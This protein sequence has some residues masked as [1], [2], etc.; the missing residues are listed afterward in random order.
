[1][2][3]ATIAFS[4]ARTHKNTRPDKT[5]LSYKRYKKTHTHAE[6]KSK[7]LA[8]IMINGVHHHAIS[9]EVNWLCPG[10]NESIVYMAGL[11]GIFILLHV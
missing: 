1:M 2:R 4:M 10:L 9:K 3:P 5:Y 11:F 6:C 7:G 8:R